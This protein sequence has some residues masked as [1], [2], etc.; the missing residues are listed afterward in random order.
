MWSKGAD[1]KYFEVDLRIDHFL[2][3]IENVTIIVILKIYW[4][5]MV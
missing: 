3:C 1:E 2:I 5:Y 4:V